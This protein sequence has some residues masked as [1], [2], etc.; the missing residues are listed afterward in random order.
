MEVFLLVVLLIL[1]A[2]AHL[3]SSARWHST[4]AAIA[5]LQSV[6]KPNLESRSKDTYKDVAESLTAIERS[7]LIHRS[8][9]ESEVAGIGLS[10]DRVTNKVDDL[11]DETREVGRRM[12][13][14]AADAASESAAT[15][16]EVARVLKHVGDTLSRELPNLEA[17]GRRSVAQGQELSREISRILIILERLDP[18]PPWRLDDC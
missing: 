4:M 12:S 2:L 17:T 5:A 11:R 13:D 10:I 1:V 6:P 7:I 18:G 16:R 8:E 3:V 9:I 14:A 15:M